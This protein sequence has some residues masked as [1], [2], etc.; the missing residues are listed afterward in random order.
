M[1]YFARITSGSSLASYSASAGM[2]GKETSISMLS[3]ATAALIKDGMDGR[4][5]RR[6]VTIKLGKVVGQLALARL[7][8]IG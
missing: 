6:L 4:L 1:K 2:S 3:L 8:L 7:D 5:T